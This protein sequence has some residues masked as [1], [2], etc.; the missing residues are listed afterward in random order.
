MVGQVRKQHYRRYLHT[1]WDY[2]GHARRGDLWRMHTRYLYMLPLMNRSVFEGGIRQSHTLDMLDESAL[3]ASTLPDSL[4]LV[5]PSSAKKQVDAAQ[6]P[7]DDFDPVIDPI[8]DGDDLSSPQP[9]ETDPQLVTS[10][11]QRGVRITR[12]SAGLVKSS[13]GP[14]S[15][16]ERP[17]WQ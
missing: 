13:L 8:D 15:M 10:G 1:Q 6:T 7:E 9:P 2:Q 17:T 16:H 3:L 12:V 4:L 5:N 11:K 14:S